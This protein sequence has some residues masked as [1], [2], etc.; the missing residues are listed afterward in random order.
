[1]LEHKYGFTCC[2][3][4][5]CQED[6]TPLNKV[7]HMPETINYRQLLGN[8]IIQTV[9]VMV[10]TEIIDRKLLQMPLIRKRQD[11]ATWAQIL[12]PGNLCY[13][14]PKVLATYRVVKGSLSANKFV[15][16]KYN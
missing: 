7:I 1:M 10:D 13:R 2:D 6:G 16:F 8:T 12:K 4:D 5:K 11:S 3:Y 15:A 9:G 14:V